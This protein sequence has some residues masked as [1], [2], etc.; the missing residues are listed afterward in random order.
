MHFHTLLQVLSRSQ[1]ALL[2][3]G[4]EQRHYVILYIHVSLNSKRYQKRTALCSSALWKAID[5]V[6]TSKANKRT[7]HALRKPQTS[8]WQRESLELTLSWLCAPSQPSLVC[9]PYNYSLL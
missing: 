6:Y 2:Q 8:L 7:R 4:I 9:N 3:L 1:I 5:A